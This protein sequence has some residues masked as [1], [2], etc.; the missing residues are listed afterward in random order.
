M[1][2]FIIQII[3]FFSFGIIVYV[4]ASA[5]PR[6]SEGDESETFSRNLFPSIQTH[7]IDLAVASFLEKTLRKT[8]LSLLRFDNT[9]NEYIGKVKA[10]TAGS[11]PNG[12]QKTLFGITEENFNRE[13]IKN[14]S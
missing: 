1:T 10:H 6:L 4:A 2:D 14:P 5:L 12:K 11:S 3:L 7:K 8:R 13:E 9:L